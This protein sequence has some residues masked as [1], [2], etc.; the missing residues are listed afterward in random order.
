[1]G[2]RKLM[3][4]VIDEETGE[5]VVRDGGKES[6]FPMHSAEAFVAA[7]RA[8]LRAGWDAKYVYSFS[9][10]GRPVIQ[11]PDDL[12]RIQEVVYRVRPDVLIETGVAHGGSLIFY[13]S[14]FKAMGNGRVIGVDIEIRPHNR[15]AIESHKLFPLITLLEGSSVDADVVEKV[16]RLVRPDE[17]V[18]VVLDSNHTRDHVLAE[19]RSYAPL[20]SVGSYIVATD[21]IMQDLVGAPRSRSDWDWNN[22]HTAIWDFLAENA[23]FVRDEPV[24][25][26][27]EGSVHS[28]VTYW[29]DAFL[30]RIR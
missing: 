27:N 22:P 10:L 18:M 20:V 9:W 26:F 19:L 12:I 30:K 24:F 28:R 29:P 15:S 14:L 23:D 2:K 5:V 7:S 25:P 13:A 17:R 11:L 21:G 6:R 1:L 8:W 16:L 4:T 3:I